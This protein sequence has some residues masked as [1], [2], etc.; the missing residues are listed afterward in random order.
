MLKLS[1]EQTSLSRDDLVHYCKRI[2]QMDE[3]FVNFYYKKTKLDPRIAILEEDFVSTFPLVA[4]VAMFKIV[5]DIVSGFQGDYANIDTSDHFLSRHKSMALS[6]VQFQK[7]KHQAVERSEL[8]AE[9]VESVREFFDSEIRGKTT[10]EVIAVY[11]RLIGH[12]GN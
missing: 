2:A 7:Q 12:I 10:H 8:T 4:N 6:E 9:E 1:R 11:E 3:N 5:A